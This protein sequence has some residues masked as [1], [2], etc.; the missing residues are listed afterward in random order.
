VKTVQ[1]GSV[2]NANPYP[3][4]SLRDVE[5][6]GEEVA[7]LV[8]NE[9]DRGN[10]G[11]TQTLYRTN[12]EMPRYIVYVERWSHWQNEYTTYKLFEATEADLDVDGQFELLG[13]EAGMTRVL[14]LDEALGDA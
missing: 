5:F 1:V 13:R 4:E 3:Q 7:S 14:S 10:R 2:W 8:V 9:D 12:E 11:E 6:E